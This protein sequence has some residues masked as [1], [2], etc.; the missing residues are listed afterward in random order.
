[1]IRI[2]LLY[3]EK[4]KVRRVDRG[5][6]SVAL[7]AM[8]ILAVGGLLG[9]FV[10]LPKQAEVEELAA[11]NRRLEKENKDLESS[12]AIM[13]LE[14]MRRQV[15]RNIPLGDVPD[16]A[17]C[18]KVAIMLASDYCRVVTGACL[19]VNGGEFLPV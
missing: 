11:K 5:Q 3:R 13:N 19:D 6:Q 15:A 4:K 1:M 18:A 16:D 14:A 2:N 7:G 9:F 8:G 17:D 10:V 12:P